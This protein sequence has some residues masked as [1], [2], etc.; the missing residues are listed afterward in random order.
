MDSQE[1]YEA[2]LARWGF[3]D[4]RLERQTR[5]QKQKEMIANVASLFK[6]LV[7]TMLHT[8]TKP[9]SLQTTH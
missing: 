4:R 9:S 8:G 5:R 6:G 7:H 2:L 3:E 1:Q